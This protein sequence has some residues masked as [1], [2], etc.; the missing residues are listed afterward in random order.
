MAT[1]VER[2][3][4]DGSP[5]FMAKIRISKKGVLTHSESKTFSKEAEAKLWAIEREREFK[6]VQV[7][8]TTDV[9]VNRSEVS[10]AGRIVSHYKLPSGSTELQHLISDRNMNSQIGEVFRSCYRYSLL[11]Q[12]DMLKEAKKIKF[13]AQAEIER[14]EKL[15]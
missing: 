6:E 11:S 13:Y 14:L 4:L 5:S 12:S 8:T 10:S 9:G 7:S 1:I 2:K 15:V 3:N